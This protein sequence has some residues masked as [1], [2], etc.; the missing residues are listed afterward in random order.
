MKTRRALYLH[1]WKN[2]IQSSNYI[3]L[4]RSKTMYV[5]IL[6]SSHSSFY[7]IHV[8][9]NSFL[10]SIATGSN[11]KTIKRWEFQIV[12]R[13][14]GHREQS[15]SREQKTPGYTNDQFRTTVSHRITLHFIPFPFR[16]KL[17]EQEQ[18]ASKKFQLRKNSAGSAPKIAQVDEQTTKQLNE[19][20]QMKE[21]EK[22]EFE[23]KI[24]HITYMNENKVKE[25]NVWASSLS[26][27]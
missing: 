20:L 4:K 1:W 22:N 2:T 13:I 3:M 10:Y 9:C 8:I 16:I 21:D 25:L 15:C 6:S 11:D 18:Q 5:F 14:K 19:I 17:S 27:T 24:Q 23:L 26:D 7:T 12:H